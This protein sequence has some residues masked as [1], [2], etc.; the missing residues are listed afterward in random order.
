MT[1]GDK[2][3]KCYYRLK[4]LIKLFPPPPPKKMGK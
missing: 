2:N 1:A 3:D 4:S